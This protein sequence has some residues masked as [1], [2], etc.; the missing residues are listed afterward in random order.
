MAARAEE[1]GFGKAA[2]TY[3]LK[4]WGVSRQRYWGT[5]IPV[6]HCKECG[7]VAVPEEQL[8]VVLPKDVAFTGKG[9][10]PLAQLDS[11]VKTACP[12]CGAAGLP[13]RAV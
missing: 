7:I 3:R 9:K 12:K 10:S 11:F 5:P 4:D 6:V 2:I 13:A 1:Q 8:P